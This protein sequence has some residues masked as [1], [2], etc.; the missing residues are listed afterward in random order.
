MSLFLH[1]PVAEVSQ[2]GEARRLAV[3]WAVGHGCPPQDAAQLALVVAELARNLV[4]HTAE[5]GVLLLR[6]LRKDPYEFELLSLD[7]GPGR[8]NFHACL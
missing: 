8:A 7:K 2:T 6:L 3:S 4:L 1:L 5:G